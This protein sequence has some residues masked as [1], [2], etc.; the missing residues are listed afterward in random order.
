MNNNE[1]YGISLKLLTNGF[2]QQLNNVSKVVKSWASKTKEDATVTTTVVDE[3]TKRF[4]ERWSNDK[5]RKFGSMNAQE[6]ADAYGGIVIESKAAGK[7]S[8]DAGNKMSVSFD[9][10]G[11]KARRF[12]LSLFSIRSAWALISR[13]SSTFLQ[14]NEQLNAQVKIIAS[15][16]GNV[17]G[18]VITKVIN[19]AEYGAIV[20]AK[21]IELFTGFNA[22]ANVTSNAFK[23]VG[24]S[25]A[26]ASKQLAGFDTITNLSENSDLGLSG[27][28]SQI[29]ALDDFKKKVA[30]VDKIFEKWGPAIKLA[31]TWLGIM[32]GAKMI[33]RLGSAIGSVSS[34]TGLAGVYS[35][36]GKISLIAAAGIIIT[37]DIVKIKELIKDLKELSKQ[38]EQFQNQAQL[39][40]NNYDGLKNKI[41]ELTKS[42]KLYGEDLDK[43]INYYETYIDDQTELMSQF[44]KQYKL[45]GQGVFV[46]K[47]YQNALQEQIKTGQAVIQNYKDLYNNGSKTQEQTK[48]YVADLIKYK[49]KL[50]EAR[51]ELK[52]WGNDTTEVD[53]YIREIDKDLK[54]LTGKDHTAKIKVDAET[55]GFKKKMSS[56]FSTFGKSVLRSVFNITGLT[57]ITPWLNSF[58]VGTNYVP[59][60]Q[61]A[62]IHKGEMIVP[63]K[64]NPATSGIGG[65]NNEQ[66]IDKLDKL[67]TT[68]ENKDTN[69]Y[70]DSKKIGQSVT[71]YINSQ[72]RIMGRSLI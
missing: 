48:E 47:E 8:E 36:L 14:E 22:L 17:L 12:L 26:K 33:A 59:N 34:L 61:L 63:A 31:T 21:L 23:N 60:D 68:L 66:I 4:N 56:I 71:N 7:A 42:G 37:I 58:D 67:I 35:L 70:M 69:V 25:A 53:K 9:G 44:I 65:L 29:S 51:G 55:S 54:S 32:F 41:T 52:R 64:Y 13:A 27:I 46:G 57:G 24:N 45:M 40:K 39:S 6:I 50:L 18:P 1:E 10:L 20:I 5:V 30:E 43:Q 49:E 16:L 3:Y 15:T 62:L 38:Y 19:Y 28:S 2:K 11:K 72:S